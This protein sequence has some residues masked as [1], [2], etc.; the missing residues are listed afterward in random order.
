MIFYLE[1]MM[2]MSGDVTDSNE[3][4]DRIIAISDMRVVNK[5][6]DGITAILSGESLVLIDNLQGALVVA[7]RA[8]PNRGVGE[9]S[10]ETVIRGSREGFT[11]TI[12]FN[13]A[14]L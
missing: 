11:E 14:L 6:S 5:L 13:T 10:G 12:R 7:N 4:K 8:W 2:K 9:P 1:P 3:I